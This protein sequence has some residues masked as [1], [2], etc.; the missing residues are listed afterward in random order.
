[1]GICRASLYDFRVVVV[2]AVDFLEILVEVLDGARD[3][4]RSDLVAVDATLSI[5]SLECF[6]ENDIVEGDGP[7]DDLDF[8][9]FVAEREDPL[10]S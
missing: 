9:V 5:S 6:D 4:D 10:A 8:E 3:L 7:W 2:A 1:M